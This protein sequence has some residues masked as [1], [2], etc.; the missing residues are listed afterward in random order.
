MAKIKV[1]EQVTTLRNWT[2]VD[3][4]LN[5]ISVRKTQVST[6]EAN[7][8]SAILKIQESYQDSINSLNAEIIGLEKNVELYCLEN[9][10]E[11]GEKQS[12][13]LNYGIVAFRKG[14]G[15][16]STLKGFTWEAVKSIV[17]KSK[18]Y[19]EM[20]IKVTASLSKEAII[21]A[22]LKETELAKIGCHIVQEENFSYELCLKESKPLENKVA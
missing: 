10:A 1:N 4:A 18:K 8:N 20:F 21:S 7:M 11:F 9:K 2:E 22:K 12:K 19:R 14:S 16:L 3:Q 6:K 17:L 13:E 5:D 15:K